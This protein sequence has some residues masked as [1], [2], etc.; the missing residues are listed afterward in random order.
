MMSIK[1]AIWLNNYFEYIQNVNF[2]YG[3]CEEIVKFAV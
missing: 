2:S 1:I 3:V